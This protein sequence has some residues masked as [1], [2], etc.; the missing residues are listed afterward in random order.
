MNWLAW[1]GG[2]W[3]VLALLVFLIACVTGFAV[4]PWLLTAY[5]GLTVVMSVAAFLTYA[6]DKWLAGSRYGRRVPERTL[7]WLELAGGWS[8][9]LVA[10]QVF[11]HKTRK[12][13]F[14]LLFWTIV[15]VHMIL[16]GL[17][18]WLALTTSASTPRP[19]PEGPPPV[20]TPATAEK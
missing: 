16:I 9:A 5:A 17:C 1:A 13:T 14:G 11:R 3:W 19:A 15:V 6:L 8:G 10:Q 4:L 2:I 7:H 18:L 20:E 12:T